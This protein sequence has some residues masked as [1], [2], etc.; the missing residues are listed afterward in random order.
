MGMSSRDNENPECAPNI[1]RDSCPFGP[2]VKIRASMVSAAEE[3]AVRSICQGW[4]PG[5]FPSKL[6]D[7]ETWPAS[8]VGNLGVGTDD[9]QCRWGENLACAAPR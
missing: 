3:I 6:D 1:A 7:E 9:N 4:G 8:R 5:F 2:I